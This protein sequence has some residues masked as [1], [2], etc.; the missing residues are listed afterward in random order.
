[1]IP[2]G[3]LLPNPKGNLARL[4][5]PFCFAL[6]AH[7]WSCTHIGLE[8]VSAAALTQVQPAYHLDSRAR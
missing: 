3:Q 6:L 1:M 7:S 5:G 4:Y 2:I 8:A